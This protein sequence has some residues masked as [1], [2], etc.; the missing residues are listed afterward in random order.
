MLDKLLAMTRHFKPGRVNRGRR[1]LPFHAIIIST[2]RLERVFGQRYR[3]DVDGNPR[4]NAHLF[5]LALDYFGK[6]H[7]R[8]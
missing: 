5:S 3:C 4:L 8:L 2:Q 1:R 6:R 7:M